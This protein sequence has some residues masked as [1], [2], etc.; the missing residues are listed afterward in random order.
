MTH[1]RTYLS[2]FFTTLLVLA[3]APADAQVNV[4]GTWQPKMWTIRIAL[5]QDGS[6]VWGSG[7]KEDFWFRGRWDG[8][9]LL[10]VA[11]NF[12]EARKGVCAPRGVFV[13]SGK[14]VTALQSV[15]WQTDT[16]RTLKG[17]WSRMSPDAGEKKPYPYAMEL[18]YCGSLRTYELAFASGSDSLSGSDWPILAAVAE[19]LKS[20]PSGK[21]EVAGHTDSTGDAK[22]NQALSERRAQAVRTILVDTYGADAARISAKGWGPDQPLQENTTPEGRALNRRVEIVLSR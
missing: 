15:W 2:L 18:E 6:M 17:P 14:T 1:R 20:N 11:N 19:V 16:G 5:H 21:I 12:R 22:S 13:L 9:R 3:S 8:D 4:T 7:G 10:L